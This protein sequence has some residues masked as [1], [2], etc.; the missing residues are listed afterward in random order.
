MDVSTCNKLKDIRST[1]PIVVFVQGGSA[2]R[3]RDFGLSSEETEIFQGGSEAQ[4][5]PS[6][7]DEKQDE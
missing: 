6:R 1:M 7:R 5:I 2:Q 4:K 3:Y